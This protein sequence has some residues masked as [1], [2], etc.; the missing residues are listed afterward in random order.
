MKRVRKSYIQFEGFTL[1]ELLIVV[2]IIA[3]LAAIAVPNFLEFQTR[4]KVSRV[5]SD[6]RSLGVAIEAYI[7]DV[8]RPPL[9]FLE[10]Y[11]VWNVPFDERHQCYIQLTTPIAYI[12][13]FFPDVFVDKSTAT[14]Q[15][16][17]FRPELQY[18]HYDQFQLPRADD[19][20]DAGWHQGGYDNGFIWS[21]YSVG[22]QH[23][24]GTPWVPDMYDPYSSA[25]Y[26]EKIANIYDP[27]NGTVSH[28]KI[29]R[30]NKG[31]LIGKHIPLV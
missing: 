14:D 29:Y 9:D 23:F 24:E 6:L 11:R 26:P 18:Y 28:G 21:L 17:V 20:Q 13:T 1:I 15:Y 10:V 30:T 16:G 31:I 4:A 27:T 22:P 8:G 12:S 7:T 25:I 19:A 3:I 2:L 5:H